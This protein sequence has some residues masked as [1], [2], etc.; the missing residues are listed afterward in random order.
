MKHLIGIFLAL[1]LTACGGGGGGGTSTPSTPTAATPSKFLVGSTGYDSAVYS[2]VPGHFSSDKSSYVV[3]SG[4]SSNGLNQTIPIKVFKIN[5]DGS[6]IDATSTILGS[7]NP[8]ASV[9]HVLVAD[10]NEDG[11]DDIFLPGVYDFP[12]KDS[13]SYVYLSQPNGQPHKLVQLDGMA[14][15]HGSMAIDINNDGH[16][17]VVNAR[18]MMWI[19]DG[20]G[21]FR[22]INRDYNVNTI[23]GQWMHGNGV[24]GGDFYKT[25]KTQL[26]ITDLQT[27]GDLPIQ[28]T[29]IFELGSDTNYTATTSHQLPMPLYDIG[30]NTG[31]EHSHDVTC[32]V[33][34][35]NGDGMLD[36]LVFSRPNL[37]MTNTPNW[38]DQ[39]AVQVLINKGNWVFED[40]T[41]TAMSGYNRNVSVSYTPIVTDLNG[42]GIPDLWVNSY[43]WT[44]GLANT[45][46]IN[47]G[48][49][50]FHQSLATQING[51][52]SNGPAVPI[53]FGNSWS[54]FYSQV[55]FS[56]NY[57]NY[58]FF[59]TQSIFNFQ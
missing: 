34:D 8:T 22:F 56:Q 18:G 4:W 46:W 20:H 58:S 44:T 25:G 24:C 5:S 30:N 3:V 57:S 23:P 27:N 36:V 26:V 47:D 33:V 21:N 37:A 31:V 38:T 43:D 14:W 15:N 42:D 45:A 52:V 13:L 17:D 9:G 48:K 54:M 19:N 2:M 32:Q 41:T 59:V 40:I 10:F 11:I 29:F 12:V 6:G 53:K 35:L 16:M 50:N 55:S 49:G 51:L 7:A 39:G 1:V 28:D